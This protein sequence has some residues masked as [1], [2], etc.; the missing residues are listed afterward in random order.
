LANEITFTVKLDDKGSL[1][2]VTKQAKKTADSLGKVEGAT[3]K[4]N[5][6]QDHFARGAKGVGQ[7]GLSASKG[8]SKMRD[9]MSGSN[10]LVSAYAI[11][12]AN[13]FAATAA[14][15]ALRRAAQI[16]QLEKGLRL[17]GAAAGQ[18]LP[19]VAK[20]LTD[21]TGAAVSSEQAMRATALAMS[22]GF[23]S[24]QLLQLTKVAKGASIAL[25]RDMGDALD[26]LVR[27]AAKLEPEILDE[28]GIMVRL[29]DAVRVYAD[30]LG[31]A[32]ESLTQ[33]ERRQAFTNAIL[34]QGLEKYEDLSNIIDSNPYDKLAASLANLQKNFINTTSSITGLAT[35]V[36]FA[37][38]NLYSLAAVATTLA[39]GITKGVAPGLFRMADSAAA[40]ASGALAAQTA[41]AGL[42][43]EGTKLPPKFAKLAGALQNGTATSKQFATA[44]LSLQGQLGGLTKKL[45]GLTE[46][47]EEYA[48]K[49]RDIQD[50]RNQMT[51]LGKLEDLQAKARVSGARA[52]AIGSAA[53]FNLIDSFTNL[54]KAFKEDKLNTDKAT[55]GKTGLKAS[56]TSLGPAFR[57]A[58]TGAKAF[59]AALF[60]ALPYLGL[61]ITIVSTLYGVIKEKF[62]PEDLVKKRIKDAIKSFEQFS[63]IAASFEMSTA[64]GGKRLANSYIA[65][66]GILDQ[67]SGKIREVSAAN[68][69]ELIS[70]MKT[71][72]V[73]LE[74][75]EKIAIRQRGVYEE[76]EKVAYKS[77]A[78]TLMQ[79]AA[80]NDATAAEAEVLRLK[81]LQLTAKERLTN[82]E[83]KTASEIT[84]GALLQLKVQAG[85][86]KK[87][88]QSAFSISL[89][90]KSMK[91]LSDLNEKL[92][93][94]DD[95]ITFEQFL[96]EF[97]LL[98]RYPNEV[99]ATF[100]SI[101][102]TVATFNGVMSKRNQ[103]IKTMFSEEED[104]AQSVLG[105]LEGL[106]E[107][108]KERLIGPVK[109]GDSPLTKEALEA[110][111][112][113]KE[114]DD[115][116]KK[117]SIPEVFGTGEASVIAFVARIKEARTNINKMEAELATS[118]AKVASLGK[119]VKGVIGGQNLL[120]EE[121][122]KV[123]REELNL[124]TEQIN[125]G[126][127][128]HDIRLGKY[129]DTVAY[130]DLLRQQNSIN[131]KILDGD[132]IS[133]LHTLDKLK[134]EKQLNSLTKKRHQNDQKAFAILAKAEAPGG[135]LTPKM[136][137]DLA[138]KLS[139]QK[140]KDAELDFNFLKAKLAAER[141]LLE[142]R[143]KADNVEESHRTKILELLDA[144]N[145]IVK[146]IGR[147]TMRTANLGVETTIQGGTGTF[148]TGFDRMGSEGFGVEGFKAQVQ[149]LQNLTTATHVLTKAKDNLKKKQEEEQEAWAAAAAAA[150][151]SLGS[152][153]FSNAM[154]A[155]DR[156]MDATKI[157]QSAMMA[158]QGAVKAAALG[159]VADTMTGMS[160][161]LEQLGPEGQ[162]AAALGNLSTIMLTS[163]VGAMEVIAESA[164][165]TAQAMSAGF[166]AA[167]N[168]IGGIA[169]LLSA[170][171]N[172]QVSAIEKQIE[173]EKKRDGQSAASVTKMKAM[174]AKKEQ[175]KKKAFET[176]KKLMIAQAIMATAAGIAGALA[177][178]AEMGGFAIALAAMIGVMGAAQIA[179]ISG[180]SYQGG[181]SAPPAPSQSV[182]V[183][184]R[185][186]SVD[187]A[188]SQ[189]G[190]GELAYMRGA[191]G[192]GGP[193]K[194]KPAF[195]GAKY[196]ASGG[197]TA[198]FMVGEQGPEMFVPDRSG[199][200]APAD[201]TAAMSNIPNVNFNISAV[202]AAGVEDVLMNQRG[203]II[204]MIREA[205][206]AQGD[207]FLEDINIAE[208]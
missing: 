139:K 169:S 16:E 151:A 128:M 15:N 187:M 73:E 159:M 54:K 76:I 137:F 129:E 44:N 184:Q 81:K 78:Q 87:T 35:G 134:L 17:V 206:N 204:S 50:V 194:F 48:A 120:H 154:D 62:F 192:Q 182:S 60:T 104:A 68:L 3:K 27:G 111:D 166:A 82:M 141:A 86:A 51:E 58:G 130:N 125:F 191:Q 199:R 88:K 33:F 52:T 56:M 72:T 115:E 193:D 145:D 170:Q 165:N 185:K 59:G 122:N 202:D 80:L 133:K 64:K 183:G 207:V 2:L 40:T 45:H 131:A 195:T 99:R 149:G 89:M 69:G 126:E 53:N 142:A 106:N 10:G 1:A 13:I 171:A 36:E 153:D 188:K 28:L 8:F 190:G 161:A 144:Q 186:G 23:R 150:K 178:T 61:I 41:V 29:D 152:D 6:S 156:A 57:I 208:L 37:S 135:R 136:E 26:R 108:S 19:D 110:I 189:G 98:Q 175:I 127:E 65:F 205:A 109:P 66:A 79:T 42:A 12:A 101:E 83:K 112:L 30:R 63:E 138:L 157:A 174:E 34:E 93:R 148:D 18:N 7:A 158:A 47:T 118:K 198:G 155:A 146:A 117:M 32:K 96:I 163:V 43:T 167:A 92:T 197:E 22:A 94:K 102:Q 119:A 121:T 116:I 162:F 143:M 38:K 4:A 9:S 55:K 95:P 180:M 160:K 97:E 203:H 100:L 20:Q 147:E 105:K 77:H 24:D 173:A 140:V 196:R 168:I 84:Y 85:V 25:G 70:K 46:G 75:Q 132:V 11:L 39:V 49:S 114:L 177:H 71:E 74:E 67:I 21:I 172:K 201:E 123:L 181:G 107:A 5:K 31:I 179:I 103:K 14:F 176:N 124:I 90:Q 113:L 91:E 200:I 164:G